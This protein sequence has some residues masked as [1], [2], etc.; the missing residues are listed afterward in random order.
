VGCCFLYIFFQ[1]LIGLQA[2]E[3]IFEDAQPDLK[4][5]NHFIMFMFGNTSGAN[6][7]SIDLQ[8]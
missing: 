3:K 5:V 1:S 2:K 7:F 8:K 6:L 4:Q